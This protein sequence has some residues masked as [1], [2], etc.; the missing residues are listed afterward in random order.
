MILLIAMQRAKGPPEQFSPRSRR[1]SQVLPRPKNA[2]EVTMA[3]LNHTRGQVA[4]VLEQARK[5]QE[6]MSSSVK[7]HFETIPATSVFGPPHICDVACSFPFHFVGK[8][9]HGFF[10]SNSI[11]T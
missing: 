2:T 4:D 7:R 11:L 9:K 5:V 8:T 6:L 10:S 3:R 1:L